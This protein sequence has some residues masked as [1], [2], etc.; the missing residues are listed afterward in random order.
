M[1]VIRSIFIHPVVKSM[2]FWSVAM[3]M[4]LGLWQAVV[5]VFHVPAFVIPSPVATISALFQNEVMIRG[6]LW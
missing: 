1:S 6:L 5:S 4:L 2:S 3:L